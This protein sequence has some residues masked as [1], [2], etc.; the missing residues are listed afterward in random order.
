MSAEDTI[1]TV[2]AEGS[3]DAR[4]IPTHAIL[5]KSPPEAIETAVAILE[6]EERIIVLRETGDTPNPFSFSGLMPAGG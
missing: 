1:L 4:A 3:I 6:S 5:S 2:L